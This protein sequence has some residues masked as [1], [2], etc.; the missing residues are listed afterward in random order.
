M[1]SFQAKIGWKSPRKKENKNY[2]SDQFLPD[3]EQRIPKKQQK[4]KKIIMASFQAKTIWEKSKRQKIKI[5]VLISSY[6]T[7]YRK[8][9]KIQL[10]ISKY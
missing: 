2:R 3:P 7:R 4:K 1:A 10:K 8:F 9:Q 6:P 5:I